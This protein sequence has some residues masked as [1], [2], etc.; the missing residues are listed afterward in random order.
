MGTPLQVGDTIS[1]PVTEYRW[2]ERALRAITLGRYRPTG[3]EVRREYRITS[4]VSA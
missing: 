4:V 3:V 2:W 1:V